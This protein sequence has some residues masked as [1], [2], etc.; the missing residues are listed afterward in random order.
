MESRKRS[1]RR[2][3]PPVYKKRLGTLLAVAVTISMVFNTPISWKGLG[4]GVSSVYASGSNA[5][6]ETIWATASNAKY[7]RGQEQ[8]VDICVIS[9]DNDVSPGNSTLMT[10]YLKNNTDEMVTD[11]SLTFKSKYIKKENGVFADDHFY[12]KETVREEEE[13]EDELEEEEL[14]GELEEE[15]L[16]EEEELHQLTD[17][18]LLPGELYEVFFE[19]YT[20]EDVKAAKASVSFS[21]SGE[22]G[23]QKLKSS[24]K[25]YYSIGLP[26]VNLDLADGPQFETGVPYEMNIWMSEPGWT[27]TEDKDEE[28]DI[29]WSPA[30]KAEKALEGTILTIENASDS[31]SRRRNDNLPPSGVAEPGSPSD[32]GKEPAT[33]KEEQEKLSEYVEKAM[34]IEPS[35]V[36]YQVEVYGTE[37]KRFR[38]QKTEEIED[39]GWINCIYELANDV[40]PGI[41]YGKVTASGKWRKKAFSSSQGFLFEV[42]GE[43]R[44]ILEGKL[45]ETKIQ[46]I[47]PVSSFPQ[48][49]LLE[50][51]VSG[52]SEEEQSIAEEAL[53]QDIQPYAMFH[54]NLLADGEDAELE[55]PV[56]VRLTSRI[57]EE[58]AKKAAALQAESDAG[59]DEEGAE[60][61]ESVPEGEAGEGR[62]DESEVT[63]LSDI[64]K[65]VLRKGPGAVYAIQN[66][67]EIPVVSR[68]S[69]TG[70]L[71]IRNGGESE[72]D[73]GEDIEEDIAVADGEQA[74]FT[75]LKLDPESARAERADSQVTK[76]GAL[77][78]ETD[79]IPAAYAL[80]DALPE[81]INSSEKKRFTWTSDEEGLTVTVDVPAGTAPQGQTEAKLVVSLV[82]GNT[83]FITEEA[84]SSQYV[85]LEKWA[86]KALNF[87]VYDPSLRFFD[88][89]LLTQEGEP[90]PI[91]APVQVTIAFQDSPL[92]HGYD[93]KALQYK[94]PGRKPTVIPAVK[95]TIEEVSG[96]VQKISFELKG[97]SIVG[98]AS[99]N[100]VSSTNT[101]GAGTGRYAMSGIF[102]MLM[103]LCIYKKEKEKYL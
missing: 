52:F 91:D 40:Q 99:A 36:S 41:Y 98:V 53:D 39:I 73:G 15:E 65:Q 28:L 8:K 85:T 10:L 86:Q 79:V 38:P 51:E 66:G 5:E 47:G 70:S 63:L 48:T 30:H 13:L 59:P 71:I 58:N 4:F 43:G 89:E 54:L 20:E 19:F 69:E 34:E 68:I 22:C 61:A 49:E 45:G 16:E 83:I 93:V 101:G 35:R 88:M 56:T 57:I 94:T 9:E 31:N 46:V 92:D 96:A 11:G 25:F 62:L 77:Q 50:L 81:P 7:K 95:E 26:Y 55:G 23:N 90:I 21:F 74:G 27:D 14:E 72:S 87:G 75:L 82:D 6:R 29:E 78:A 3:T 42:T 44:I 80:I 37:W 64:P 84:S 60:E 103:A 67:E 97:L 32:A 24:E 1:R 33:V 2:R 76:R 17:L 12:L 100:T 18:T 102:I